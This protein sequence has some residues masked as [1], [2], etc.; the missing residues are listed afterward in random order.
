M[1]IPKENK[2]LKQMIEIR[3]VKQPVLVNKNKKSMEES[4]RDY[5]D[6]KT[7]HRP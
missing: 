1:E 5:I 7:F 2:H 4:A 6:Y 3:D